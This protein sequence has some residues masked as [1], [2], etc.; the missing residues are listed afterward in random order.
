MALSRKYYSGRRKSQ[1]CEKQTRERTTR[2]K[3]DQKDQTKKKKEDKKK[4]I[5][6]I[7]IGSNMLNICERVLRQLEK[8]KYRLY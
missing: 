4:C 6:Q 1:Y 2:D 5:V 7:L 8:F 3:S